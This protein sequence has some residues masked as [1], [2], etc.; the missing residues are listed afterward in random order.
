VRLVETELAGAALRYVSNPEFLREGQ[1]L[2]DWFH[3]DRIVVGAQDDTSADVVRALY[4]GIDA[5]YVVTDITTAEM[6]SMPAMH[7]SR[8]RSP[9][10]T[11]L[12]SYASVLEPASTM[13]AGASPWTHESAR[14]S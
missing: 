10:S 6:S 11:R 13:S 1:A 2:E 4:E 12:R 7:S 8:P 5:P 14:A 3:P 9:S